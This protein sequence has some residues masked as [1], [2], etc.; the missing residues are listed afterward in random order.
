MLHVGL[1]GGDPM[2]IDQRLDP[3]LPD[4]ASSD[5]GLD[6]FLHNLVS[7]IGE[8]EVPH[9]LSESSLLTDLNRGNPEGLLP[10]F[11]RFWVVTSSH[12]PANI[13][14]VTFA[15]RP[16]DQLIAVKDGLEDSHIGI[17]ISLTKD[18]IVNDH[19]AG[20]DLLVEIVDNITTNGLEGEGQYGN[21]FGL[22]QHS[23]LMV[24]ESRNEVTS[25]VE[26]GRPGRPEEGESHLFSNGFETPLQYRNK[27]GIDLLTIHAKPNLEVTS[28]SLDCRYIV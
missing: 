4:D 15:S 6:V 1:K 8:D 17:L 5:L 10:Y 12:G 7:D 2:A 16:G 20:K 9:I 26:D 21:V 13:R 14:L 28:D 19:I 3:P 27:N 24:V 11:P 23:A 22:L 18:I 25:L